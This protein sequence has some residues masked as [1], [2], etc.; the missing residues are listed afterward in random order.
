M[1][2]QVRDFSE[3]KSTLIKA[4]EPKTEAEI[5]EG[6]EFIQLPT[7]L[8]ANHFKPAEFL[9]FD[10]HANLAGLVQVGGVAK[11]EL[12]AVEVTQIHL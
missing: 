7:S 2:E 6:L 12:V 5:R 8:F 4:P 1:A 3:L 9:L 10:R 11:T